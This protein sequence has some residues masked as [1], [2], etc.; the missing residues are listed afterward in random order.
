MPP[1]RPAPTR[2]R[3]LVSAV[4]GLALLC[5][6]LVG[7]WRRPAPTAPETVLLAG[8]TMGTIFQVKVVV[9]IA[10]A[11]VLD[12]L[13]D[14]VEAELASVDGA[15]SHYRETSDISRLN[16]GDG[17]GWTT[18]AAETVEVLELARGISERSGGAF[19][20]TVAPLVGLWGFHRKQPLDAEPDP[21]QIATL[22]GDVGYAL[23]ELDPAGPA[24][25]KER[26]GVQIDLSA[27]AK[28][29]GV[30]RVAEAIEGQGYEHYLVE[31]GGE[32]RVRGHNAAGTPWRIGIER[33]VDEGRGVFRALS[34]ADASMATSGDY[35]SFYELAGRRVSHTI[36][37]RTAR[38]V[39]HGLA[40]VTVIHQRCALADGWATALMVLGPGEGPEVAEREGL[41]ALFLTRNDDGS[42][43]ERETPRFGD[44]IFEPE[45]TAQ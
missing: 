6:L 35:R 14:G 15:L 39:E 28:G 27:V 43:D 2:S 31:V 23:L 32:V 24:V 45:E 22:G 36:D 19:D 13:R 12:S 30:D 1:P 42:F 38:P 16:S 11:E 34:L 21:E 3:I 33:P 41:A 4:A 20:V 18:V 40:S 25:R 5:A 17:T 7:I 29:Y 44:L 10:S 37:P 26:S 9:P 8:E